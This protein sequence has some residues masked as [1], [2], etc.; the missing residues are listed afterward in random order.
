MRSRR[1]CARDGLGSP[2]IGRDPLAQRSCRTVQEGT[3]W[4]RAGARLHFGPSITASQLR[5]RAEAVKAD[6]SLRGS[7]AKRVALTAEHAAARS[8][9][10]RPPP[11]GSE[12]GSEPL[13][14]GPLPQGERGTDNPAPARL[15]G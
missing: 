10:D 8:P 2:G 3:P 12:V 9:A 13:S 6:P 5:R 11:T 7:P 4:K 15:Q 1:K 14:P